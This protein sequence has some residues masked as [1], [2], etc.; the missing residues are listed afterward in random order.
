MWAGKV[1]KGLK[2][3]LH[4]PGSLSLNP[5]VRYNCKNNLPSKATVCVPTTH[6]IYNNKC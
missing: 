3:L 2:H 5:E 6:I 4:K 1:A